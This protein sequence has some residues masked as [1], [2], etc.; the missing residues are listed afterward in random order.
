MAIPALGSGT[1]GKTGSM[2]V[3]RISHTAT[4][5]AD[6]EVL[7]AGGNSSTLGISYL[8][9]AELYNPS[10]GTWS[11]TGSMTVARQRHQAVLLTSGEVLVAGGVNASDALS[12]AELYD[13][14]TGLWTGTGSIHTAR[15]GFSLTLLPDGEALAVQ[16]T[17]AELYNPATGTWTKTA[18]PTSSVGGP[19][20]PLLQDGQ[21]LAIGESIN[22]PSELYNPSTGTWSTTGS[23]GTTIINPITPRFSSGQVLVTGGFSSGSAS[24]STAALYDP[25]TGQFTLETGPCNCRGFNGALLQ[26]GEVLVA[27]GFIT[28]H[29]RPY[30]ITETINSAELW[31]L[32]TQT[33]TSTGNLSISRGG[34]SLTI[35]SN[36]QALVAGGEHYDKQLLITATAELYR[37]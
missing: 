1:W 12:S 27:G 15:S 33:W 21:V 17:S 20:A 10:T 16:G 36:G 30:N 11:L 7:V 6:G 23:T 3:A 29:A 22:T 13:P 5:L 2:N 19:S 34:E 32:S 9:S 18:S 28:V 26:T 24:Y 4:L 31:N 14:S 37:P 8:A 35:L 25:S